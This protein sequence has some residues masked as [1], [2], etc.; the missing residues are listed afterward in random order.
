VGSSVPPPVPAS[1]TAVTR[2]VDVPLRNL[3]CFYCNGDH[4]I[5][6]CQER[7]PWDYNAPFFGSE[8]FG[9]GFY[10]IPVPEE[11][12]YPV[13]QLNY[14]HITVEKGEVNCRNIE[15]EFN[16]WAESMK[17]NWRF[18]AKEVSATEF[19]TRFPSAK[20][21]E[22]L[23]H[24]GKLFMR[25][26][27]GAIISLEKWAG[28]IEPISIMQEA[29]FRIKG[30]PM[31]FR[32]KSTVYY[33]ASLVGKPLALDKN[34]LRHFAYVR[35]KIGSQDLALVPNSRIGEIKKGFYEFQ[36]SRELFDPSFNT[37]N[38]TAVSTDAQG[39]EGDQGTPKR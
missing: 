24:F 30:I 9:S 31:K 10:S 14:A 27:P 2:R 3:S 1:T 4:H 23:A 8:E 19:R 25:T 26:V 17:I 5:S 39:G 18:F 12:N 22:E 20:T 13:E 21:I 11:D 33:A 28:D 32:N 34:Y 29:W 36:Y 6:V 7:D 15:H 37:G 16:V 35:V 38:K